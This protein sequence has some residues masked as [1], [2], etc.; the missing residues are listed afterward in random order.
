MPQAR[1]AVVLAMAAMAAGCGGPAAGTADGTPRESPGGKVSSSPLAGPAG[2]GE[3]LLTLIS[4][5]D[6]GVTGGNDLPFEKFGKYT[7]V[8]GGI[9]AGD[10]DGDGLPDLYVVSEG[11]PSHLYRNLGDWRFEDTTAESGVTLARAVDAG[12][13]HTRYPM[14]AT[15][16]DYNND[17]HL[18]LYVTAFA[19][20]NALLENDGDGTFTDVTAAAGVG[21]VGASTTATV[22]D[23][24]RDG[25]VDIFVATY[26]PYGLS[27]L[28]PAGAS[29]ADLEYDLE[30]FP[31]GSFILLPEKDVLYH[32]NG[33]GTFSNVAAEAGVGEH[34]DWGLGA[35]FADANGDGW[36]DLY[37]SN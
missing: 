6:S 23:Y 2:A 16:L 13:W 25:Y 35:R 19:G 22:A 33:D 15:F 12:R 29:E 34:R 27:R 1:H 5:E 21:Y 7:Q 36:P 37:V 11:G 26:R 9:A 3:T 8:G 4:P 32:N 24:D 18:D 14:G 30:R 20:A 28:Y 10:Y 31:D 17:G